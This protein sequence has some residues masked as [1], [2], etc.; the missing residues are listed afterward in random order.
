MTDPSTRVSKAGA[1]VFSTLV[2]LAPLVKESAILQ[3]LPDSGNEKSDQVMDHLIQ[4]QP[5]P[6]CEIHPKVRDAL[7]AAGV[8]LRAY[9]LDGITWL[10]FLQQVGLNGALTDAMGLGKTVQ[11]LVGISLAHFDAVDSSSSPISLVVCPSSV[12][13]HWAKEVSRFFPGGTVLRH[14]CIHGPSKNDQIPGD[15]TL[16]ITSYTVLRSEIDVL[17]RRKWT[18]VVLDEG[19]LLK[20]P[21]TATAKAVRRL[22][23]RFKLI[24]TGTPVQN[25]VN[26]VWAAFDFLMPNFLGSSAD[27]SREFAKPI[28]KGQAAGA[29]A[30]DIALMMEK[31]KLLHQQ[32]LPFILRREKEHVLKELPPKVMTTIPCEMSSRQFQ[33]YQNFCPSGQGQS[34][35]GSF[36]RVLQNPAPDTGLSNLGPE[37]LKAMLYLRLV[38]THPALVDV[39]GIPSNDGS[40]V[41]D[42]GKL[43]ALKELFVECGLPCQDVA[44]ADNDMSLLYIRADESDEEAIDD[45]EGVLD[46]SETDPSYFTEQRS[47]RRKCLV[48]AQFTSSLDVV[49]ELLHHHFPAVSYLRLDGKVPVS[50]RGEIVDSFNRDEHI[51]ILLLTTRI[52]GLGLNL[53]G[54]SPTPTGLYGLLRPH[55]NSLRSLQ[56]PTPS[57]F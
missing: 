53:T 37:V 47:D 17:S 33:L 9:Q 8:H 21:K 13:G 50:R 44:A 20:N 12:L 56:V 14:C 51:K 1:R 27:F 36:H 32:V 46:A 35:L 15:C 45:F 2:Q 3:L 31:L 55:R 19:H 38:C 6:P 25:K 52:G 24:L 41:G 54:R 23:S 28:S 49:E 4:G 39:N 34:F 16:V 26:E 10:R 29:G 22:Q 48:F 30:A 18:Y 42:S 43:L 40:Q 11:A 57:F 5:L 7:E